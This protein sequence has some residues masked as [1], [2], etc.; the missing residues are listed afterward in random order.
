MASAAVSEEEREQKRARMDP[1]AARLEV[2][3]RKLEVRYLGRTFL[4]GEEVRDIVRLDYDESDAVWI[5]ATVSR[6]SASE[7]RSDEEVVEI[8]YYLNAAS[9]M[10][11]MIEAF[12]RRERGPERQ[13]ERNL[14]ELG[15]GGVIEVLWE[16]VDEETEESQTVWWRAE[17]V[18]KAGKHVLREGDEAVDLDVWKINYDARP[19]LSEP[20]AVQHEVC[21]LSKRALF[22]VTDDEK[23]MQWRFEGSDDVIA[24]LDAELTADGGAEEQPQTVHA[25]VDQLVEAAVTGALEGSLK[26]KFEAL[27]RDRQCAVADLVVTAKAKLK[28]ALAAHVAAKDQA[29]VTPD[30]VKQVI[31]ALKAELKDLPGLLSEQKPVAF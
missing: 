29:L 10:D 28:S 4:D 17:V 16:V 2:R 3:K 22:D 11:E 18:E 8:P 24:D 1:S 9:G 27:P 19:E 5:A 31:D 21:F 6:E 20:E 13:A 23:V 7:T 14:E 15:A 12:R 26:T 25:E 30:D